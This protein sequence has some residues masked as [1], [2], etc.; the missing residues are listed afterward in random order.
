MS[1]CAPTPVSCACTQAVA[2]AD[3][4]FDAGLQTHSVKLVLKRLQASALVLVCL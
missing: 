3:A 4:V 1:G 2:Q